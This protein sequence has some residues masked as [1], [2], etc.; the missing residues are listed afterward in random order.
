MVIGCSTLQFAD[1]LLLGKLRDDEG[2]IRVHPILLGHFKAIINHTALGRYQIL[3]SET[4][5]DILLKSM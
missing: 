1:T 4:D 2:E 3:C 5:V